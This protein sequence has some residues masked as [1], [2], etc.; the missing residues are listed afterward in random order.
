MSTPVFTKTATGDGTVYDSPVRVRQIYVHTA[1]S[2]SPALTLHDSSSAT[3]VSLLTLSFTANETSNINIPDN[4]IRFTQ[5]L[6]ADLT[7][8]KRVTFFL[9]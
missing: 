6:Y 5:K 7:S 3:T 8:M 9:S 4:G 1:T 2:G